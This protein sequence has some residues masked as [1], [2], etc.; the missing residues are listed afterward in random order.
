MNKCWH[1]LTEILHSMSYYN[2]DYPHI[3][4]PHWTDRPECSQVLSEYNLWSIHENCLKT[5]PTF[6]S[7]LKLIQQNDYKFFAQYFKAKYEGMV[8]TQKAHNVKGLQSKRLTVQLAN[9]LKDLLFNF[10]MNFIINNLS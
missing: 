4:G 10:I 1:N 6:D 8:R 5:D 9:R 2:C 7:T 3:P